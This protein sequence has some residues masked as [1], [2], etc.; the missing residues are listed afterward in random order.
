VTRSLSRAGSA[1]ALHEYTIEAEEDGL[2]RIGA[3][4]ETP[5][6]ATAFEHFKREW[7][8]KRANPSGTGS[9]LPASQEKRPISHFFQE[10]LFPDAPIA[11]AAASASASAPDSASRL[12]ARNKN[13][14][15]GESRIRLHPKLDELIG[16]E[17][18]RRLQ[19]RQLPDCMGEPLEQLNDS[20]ELSWC[21]PVLWESRRS[22]H[23][24]RAPFSLL[25]IDSELIWDDF[26]ATGDQQAMDAFLHQITAHSAIRE[27]PDHHKT[28]YFFN[29]RKAATR[30]TAALNRSFRA[31]LAIPTQQAQL[32]QAAEIENRLFLLAASRNVQALF[33]S[34]RQDGSGVVDLVSLLVEMSRC[35]AWSP[36]HEREI[37]KTGS[38]PGLTLA[39]DFKV[40]SGKDVQDTW[41]RILEQIPRITRSV[42]VSIA[43]HPEYASFR[44]L[45]EAFERKRDKEEQAVEDL[46]NI[47]LEGSA[48]RIGPVLA[49]RVYDHFCK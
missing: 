21:W 49:R 6:T 26:L 1:L 5:S 8:S 27:H 33:S 3:S 9:P 23:I 44:R 46:A 18:R 37:A 19:D 42:A 7:R 40:R 24:D 30:H 39:G 31:A 2:A 29:W 15:L 20:E 48:K 25:V 10:P 41:L 14:A 16:S 4:L 32:V 22:G 34:A 17:F 12:Q 36:Y 35:I 28:V 11:L 47:Q 43:S 45:M 13:E 38:V